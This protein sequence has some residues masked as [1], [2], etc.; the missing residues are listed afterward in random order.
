MVVEKEFLKNILSTTTREATIDDLTDI[1][2]VERHSYGDPWSLNVLRQSLEDRHA[3]NLIALK[4]TDRTV[5][6]FIINGIVIDELHILNIAVSP[7][8]R[9][10]G[11]GDALLEST[12]YNAKARGCRTAYLEVRR[13][14][15]PAL[16]LYIKKGFKVTGVR[17]G[18]YSDNREDAL[19]MT[20]L[21]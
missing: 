3:F 7:E 13:S 16:T 20:K 5:T 15:L 1:W 19:L 6:G 12:I 17:R 18:Y 9:R 2:M 4:E 21:L 8:F 10:Y 14:N 11:I